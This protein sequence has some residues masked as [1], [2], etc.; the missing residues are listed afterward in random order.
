MALYSV[1]MGVVSGRNYLQF[2]QSLEAYIVVRGQ[3]SSVRMAYR[4]GIVYTSSNL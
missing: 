4:G 1:V 2:L 3:A